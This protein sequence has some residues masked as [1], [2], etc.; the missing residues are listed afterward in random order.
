MGLLTRRQL[1]T[2]AAGLSLSSGVVAFPAAALTINPRS[3]WGSN[4]PPKGPPSAEDVKFLLVHHSA[5]HNGYTS[6]DTPGI[7]R[8]WFNYHTGPDKGWNDIAY[9]FIIDSGGVMWEGREGSL[10]GA[11]AGDATGGN[12]GFSQLVCVIGDF[13]TGQPTSAALSSLRAMLAWL[14]DRHAVATSE[15]SEVTFTSRGSDK[16]SAGTEVTTRTIAGHRNMSKTSCP[17]DNLYSYV[18]GALMADV[19]TIRVGGSPKPTTTSSTTT[20]TTEPTTTTASQ[21]KIT[22]T[23]MKPTTTTSTIPSTTTT[24][25]PSTTTSLASSTPTSPVTTLAPVAT[26][27]TTIPVAIEDVEATSG[28]P[29]V[30]TG[31]AVLVV[32]GAGLLLWRQRRMGD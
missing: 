14:A 25:V 13:N 29:V 3:A 10:A 18:V 6:A 32:A 30:L 4:H 5:S 15:G 9:N 12:Q 1:I 20:T 16:W 26:P 8:G 23:T 11:V 7:L 28:I 2:A 21:A 17:G 24:V 19:Q 22:T 31:S 27:P